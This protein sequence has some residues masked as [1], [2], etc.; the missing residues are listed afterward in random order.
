L[1]GI[2]AIS[3]GIFR[4]CCQSLQV[5]AGIVPGL[6]HYR[7]PANYLRFIIVVVTIIIIIIIIIIISD[8]M[9]LYKLHTESVVE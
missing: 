3:P 5:K 4:G 1:T 6:D 8:P 2:P 7:F 9:T